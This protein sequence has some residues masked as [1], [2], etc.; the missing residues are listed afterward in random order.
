MNEKT[1]VT[2]HINDVC[3]L[4]NG[5]H[6]KNTDNRYRL[7]RIQGRTFTLLDVYELGVN[8]NEV[9]VEADVRDVQLIRKATFS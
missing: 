9:T 3:K 2:Y 6:T 8:S 4:I 5:K 7:I 1:S